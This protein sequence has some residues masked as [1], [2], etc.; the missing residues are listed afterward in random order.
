M[1]MQRADIG[2]TLDYA[3]WLPS[4]VIEFLMLYFWPEGRIQFDN[5]LEDVGF[6]EV[7][8]PGGA[9]FTGGNH[10]DVI[11]YMAR[12]MGAEAYFNV[13]GDCVVNKLPVFDETVTTA[14]A[15]WE[16]TTGETGILTSAKKSITR[17]G[18]Y[19]SVYVIGAAVEGGDPPS[20]GA[21]NLDPNSPTYREGPFRRMGIKITD[22]TLTSNEQCQY[23]AEQKLAEVR[24][25]SQ[26]V[27]FDAIPNPAVDVGDIVMIEYLSGETQVGMIESFTLP[28]GGGTFSGKVAVARV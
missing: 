2:P 17:D 26:T 21:Q 13:H 12:R 25:L 3:G 23:V 5:A 10:W 1:V 28:I 18:V 24:R 15:V 27:E 22:Q 20:G 6:S 7:R 19:N 14:D 9:A 16:V 11:Q 4:D 8:V